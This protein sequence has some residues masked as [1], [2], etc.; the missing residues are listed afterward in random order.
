MI[1]IATILLITFACAYLIF[2]SE[3]ARKQRFESW[4]QAT[5]DKTVLISRSGKPQPQMVDIF[6]N[7][8]RDPLEYGYHSITLP[9]KKRKRAIKRLA[10][11]GYRGFANSRGKSIAIFGKGTIIWQ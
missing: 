4:K 5:I 10:R 6:Y 2:R 9:F 8:G 3:W 1:W 11:E 7:G